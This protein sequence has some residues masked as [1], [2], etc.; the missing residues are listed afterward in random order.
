MAYRK[1][2]R[3]VLNIS[4]A[5]R[6]L[7]ACLLFF[8]PIVKIIVTK[9]IPTKT[10]IL[11]KDS[12]YKPSP[13]AACSSVIFPNYFYISKMKPVFISVLQTNYYYAAVGVQR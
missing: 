5:F 10:N 12:R 8:R 6:L 13:I 1:L 9:G 7:N 2:I 11:I 4:F 3:I